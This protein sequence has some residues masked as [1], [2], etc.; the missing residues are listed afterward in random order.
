MTS[1]PARP[2]RR[3][4]VLYVDDQDGNLVVFRASLKKYVDVVTA[5]SGKE[6][7]A[8]VEKEE[9]PIVISDQ[10]MEGMSGTELLAEVRRIRPDTIRMLLTA[11][12]DFDDV[13]RAINDG[14]VS[15]FISKPWERQDLLGAIVNAHELLWKNKENRS[16]TEQ[17]LHRERLAA[18]GQVTSG[19]VHELGNIAAVLAVTEDI[20][21]DWQAGKDLTRE[22]EIL[23]AGVDKFMLLVESLRIYSKG[24]N[25]LDVNKKA[26]DLNDVVATTLLLARLFPV[27]KSLKALTFTRL[28][29]AL[30]APVDARKMEQVLL[31]LVKNAAEACA[32]GKGEVVISLE[33]KDASALIRIRD[34]GPGIPPEAMSKIWEGFYSTKGEKGTGLGLSMCRKIMTAHGGSIEVSTPPEGG[35]LFTLELPL[36]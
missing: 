22:L 25:Q 1:T 20:R 30:V 18:I 11:Y 28:P 36:G 4:R 17:L 29:E 24:G 2:E 7:L 23:K 16:L 19:L 10:R 34:N 3:P 21:A 31:N 15:R 12:S 14:Q 32:R 26:T 6:A 33:R 9:F 5:T 27:V 8:L 35:S 13:V